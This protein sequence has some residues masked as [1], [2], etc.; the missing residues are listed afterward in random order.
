MEGRVHKRKIGREGLERET[1]N[2]GFT[3]GNLEGKLHKGKIG[4]EGAQ[5]ENWKGG[6]TKEKLE[7]R[8]RQ[9]LKGHPTKRKGIHTERKP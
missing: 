1:C 8:V 9:I 7:R 3:K 2:V 6:S 4:R 5:E